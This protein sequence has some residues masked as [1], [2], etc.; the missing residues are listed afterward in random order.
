MAYRQVLFR[1][2]CY[3]HV[4][5]VAVDFFP[6]LFCVY[7]RNTVPLI[8]FVLMTCFAAAL[9]LAV[10]PGH[11]YCILK[12]RKYSIAKETNEKIFN[13]NALKHVISFP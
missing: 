8:N 12:T 7:D 4:T 6:F 9:N 3:F 5:V 10:V 1:V 13:T 11:Q 2:F